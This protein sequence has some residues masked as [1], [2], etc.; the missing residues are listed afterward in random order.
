[1]L[2]SIDLEST[3][4]WN[5]SSGNSSTSS[6]EYWISKA[7]PVNCVFLGKDIKCYGWELQPISTIR[8]GL[9]RKLE[10]GYE[11]IS[12]LATYT[13]TL[14]EPCIPLALCL[15]VD[16]PSMRYLIPVWCPA[17][18]ERGG[19]SLCGAPVGRYNLQPILV[20][21]EANFQ[22]PECNPVHGWRCN[23]LGR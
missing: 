7:I 13:N 10:G 21:P 8:A 1:M 4:E 2:C 6:P 14:Q 18:K 5:H 9:Q 3:R 20:C 12:V 22:R 23:G 11:F 19:R 16:T 15:P 17:V